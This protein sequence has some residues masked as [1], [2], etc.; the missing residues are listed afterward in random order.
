MASGVPVIRRFITPWPI[1]WE[2]TATMKIGWRTISAIERTGPPTRDASSPA[3][4][5]RSAGT[6]TTGGAPHEGTQAEHGQV[7]V[8]AEVGRL[9][10][11]HGGPSEHRTGEGGRQAADQHE[12][13]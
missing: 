7:E 6:H 9:E 13:D 4:G 11:L 8:R 3:A 2:R 1:I 10:D 5:R 12:R